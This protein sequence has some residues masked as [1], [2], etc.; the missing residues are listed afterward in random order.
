MI[1]SPSTNENLNGTRLQNYR[2]TESKY[3]STTVSDNLYVCVYLTKRSS[4]W[5]CSFS[6]LLYTWESPKKVVWPC[7]VARNECS[8]CLPF[9]FIHNKVAN[10]IV[11]PSKHV[12]LTDLIRYKVTESL[13]II[14]KW[15]CNWRT[16][17]LRKR[18]KKIFNLR[19]WSFLWKTSI[20]LIGTFAVW[21]LICGWLQIEIV[22]IFGLIHVF[23]A[24]KL[25]Y[26]TK[27]SSISF[28][29]NADTGTFKI[30]HWNK[31][32]INRNYHW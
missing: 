10:F 29:Q 15:S 20:N 26:S 9:D 3:D 17:Q 31:L 27:R 13:I 28:I 12:H 11:K 8:W 18:L 25:S 2:S 5:I 19:S 24:S 30:I 6:L 14:I 32:K 16:L 23:S 7:S 1:S 21:K 22:W 4:K